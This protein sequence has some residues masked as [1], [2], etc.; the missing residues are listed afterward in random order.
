[1]PRSIASHLGSQANK[2][3]P[4]MKAAQVN[5]NTSQFKS[6]RWQ[7]LLAVFLH[8]GLGSFVGVMPGVKRVPSCSVCMVRRFF[9]VSPSWCLAA[10]LW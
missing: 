1:M 6:R 8:V 3:R 4:P 5:C 2:E 10:S 9:V 7:L